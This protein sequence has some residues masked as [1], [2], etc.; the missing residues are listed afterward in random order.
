[1][2]LVFPEKEEGDFPARSVYKLKRLS[3]GNL[4]HYIIY[5]TMLVIPK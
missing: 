3:E 2:A 1:M 4:Y 5:I